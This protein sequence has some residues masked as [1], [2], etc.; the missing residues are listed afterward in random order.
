MYII[1]SLWIYLSNC[2]AFPARSKE[3]RMALR[4]NE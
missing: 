4:Y 3:A 1:V 2:E